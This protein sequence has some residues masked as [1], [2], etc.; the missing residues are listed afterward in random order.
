MR[1]IPM[2]RSS[3][4][5]R[6]AF[7][8]GHIEV[9]IDEQAYAMTRGVL[10]SRALHRAS[11]K[12]VA[13]VPKLRRQLQGALSRP[14]WA[15]Q[16]QRHQRLQRPLPAALPRSTLPRTVYPNLLIDIGPDRYGRPCRL[17]P[18]AAHAWQR[19][20]A[21]ADAAGIELELVSGF[22]S[23]GYQQAI[24]R[25]KLARGQDPLQIAQVSAIPGYSEHH[26]GRALDL[27]SGP[28]PVLEQS[29]AKTAAYRWLQAHAARFGFRESYPPNNPYGIVPEPW[30]WCWQRQPS[31]LLGPVP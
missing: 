20:H 15:A 3:T 1:S 25:R 28:D 24:W 10:H 21:A 29:F 31:A 13:A 5:R 30:H 19:M 6:R 14:A 27:A 16:S 11:G 7:A 26:S 12:P 23:V 17:Q 18:A 9:L 22:R 8:L 4:Q 2:L